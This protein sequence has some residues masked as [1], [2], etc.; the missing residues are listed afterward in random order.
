MARR[1][2]LRAPLKS[3]ILYE[4]DGD[5][6]KAHCLNVSEGGILIDQ[7]PCVPEVKVMPIMFAMNLLPN[8]QGMGR[9]RIMALRKSDLD[10][11]VLRARTKIVRSFDGLSGVDKVFSTHIGCQ[12]VNLEENAQES[13]KNYVAVFAKNIVYLLTLFES[14]QN[15]QEQTH[16][17]RHV[18]DFLGYDTSIKISQLR[19]KVLHDYQSLEGL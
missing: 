17:L 12:F 14:G 16:V 2:H 7:L 15:S 10:Q 6:L 4:M 1:K 5:V 9:E 18:G 13:I 19:Q 3:D 8:F 11:V